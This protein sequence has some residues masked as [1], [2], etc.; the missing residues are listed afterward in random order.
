MSGFYP[1]PL[2]RP[3]VSQTSADLLCRKCQY[4]LRGLTHDS[5]CPECGSPVT[6][7]LRSDQI[8]YS[9]PQWIEQVRLGVNIIIT[10]LLL[11]VAAYLFRVVNARMQLFDRLFP[12]ILIFVTDVMIAVGVWLMTTP[13][14][15]G[16]GETLY[17]KPRRLARWLVALG[18][19]DSAWIAMYRA[20]VLPP[21]A[22]LIVNLIA[23]VF[24]IAGC[25]GFIAQLKFMSGLA[26]RI[27]NE[28]LQQRAAFLRLALGIP[29]LLTLAVSIERRLAPFV[30]TRTLFGSVVIV[31]GL[32]MVAILIFGI[33]YL[34]L[35]DR[36][37]V[38]L[39]KQAALAKATWNGEAV[40]QVP[41]D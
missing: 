28:T 33:M 35:L 29:L 21:E 36:F 30:I 18:L 10:G 34:L 41:A 13:D 2:P 38:E 7:S 24:A 26:Q 11:M 27:P 17:G 9:N 19:I 31:T 22:D 37:R 14:P 20:V 3:V 4:N 1:P 23:T 6:L 16:L 15:G 8:R 32:S 5:L 12:Q 25:L 40:R 39:T